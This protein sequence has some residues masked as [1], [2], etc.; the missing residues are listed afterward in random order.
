M[1]NKLQILLFLILFLNIG[2]YLNYNGQRTVMY[3][4]GQ[5][6]SIGYYIEGKK[7]A[8][9]ISIQKMVFYKNN[10]IIIMINCMENVF[11][12]IMMEV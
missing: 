2:C 6:K 10:Y 8:T 7:M 11:G 5:L 9:L 3:T 12:M 1:I 4:N